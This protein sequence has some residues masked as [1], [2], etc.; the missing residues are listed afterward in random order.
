MSKIIE[1][2]IHLQLYVTSIE[3][4]VITEQHYGFRSNHSTELAA[5]NLTDAIMHELVSNRPTFTVFPDL[6]KAFDTLNHKI[7]LRKLYY[8]GLDSVAYNLIKN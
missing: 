8:Y 4:N 7:I 3:N 1:R 5:L 6:S 2:V